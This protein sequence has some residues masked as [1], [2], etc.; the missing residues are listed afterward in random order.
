[1][2][3]VSVCHFACNIVIEVEG[4]QDSVQEVQRRLFG[5]CIA[6]AWCQGAV[7]AGWTLLC[8]E[9]W[10]SIAAAVRATRIKKRNVW[11]AGLKRH[12]ADLRGD[13][14]PMPSHSCHA[15]ERMALG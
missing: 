4:E 14:L 10:H 5:G 13:T 6:V 3:L 8:V 1:M 2:T 9:G 11:H 12:P 15:N 7:L